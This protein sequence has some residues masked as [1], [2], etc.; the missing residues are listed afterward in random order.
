MTDLRDAAFGATPG[1]HPLP[2]APGGTRASWWRAVALGGQGRYAA[3][4]TELSAL[5]RAPD[6]ELVSLALSTAASHRRQLGRHAAARRLDARAL[7]VAR[8]TGSAAAVA[9]AMVGLAADHLGLGDRPGTLRLLERAAGPTVDAE[10]RCTLRWHWVSA[11]LALGSG[12][13]T[14]AQTHAGLAA[15]HATVL[16]S[17]RHQAKSRLLVLACAVVAGTLDPLDLDDLDAA[18]RRHGLLPLC[19]ATALLGAHDGSTAAARAGPAVTAAQCAEMIT[20]RGGAVAG[21][22]W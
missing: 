4:A 7:V 18:T 1:T 13:P 2:V 19:W 17:V 3:A 9:D 21:V 5:T 15:Q 10:Q 12:A 16:G 6:L 20:L 8:G 22:G 11:E 14:D